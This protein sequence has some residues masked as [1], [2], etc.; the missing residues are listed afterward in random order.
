VNTPS[1]I[2]IPRP[3]FFYRIAL[4]LGVCVSWPIGNISAAENPRPNVIVIMSD[5]QGSID[6]GCY[7]A[8][9]IQTPAIDALAAS[10]VRFTQFY[11][12]APVCSP[13]R[14]GLLTGRYPWLVGMPGNGPVPP[15]EKD[16][17]LATYTGT[18]LPINGFTLPGMFR[19][20]GY[21]TAHIGKWHLG[22]GVGHQPLQ[23]GFDYSFGFMGGCIDNY[24]HFNYWDHDNRHDLWEN[25]KRV[26]MSGQFFPDLMIQKAKGFLDSHRSQP[27]F[28]YFAINVPHYPYQGDP[29]WLDYYNKQGVPYPR[30]LYAAFVSS[31]DDRVAQLINYLDQT[32]LRSNTIV[33]YQADN[34]YSTEQ[35]AHGGGGSSGPYRGAKFSIFEGGTRLPA[36]ISWP[37]HFPAGQ[38]RGQMA[39]GCDWL[40]TLAEC[41]GISLPATNNLDGRSL[42]K[43]IQS[44]D[45]TSPHAV[46]CWR[47]GDQW[48]VRE[49]PWK[50]MRDPKTYSKSPEPALVDGHWFL[51]NIE[52]DP[53]EQ[54]NLAAENPEVVE[55]LKKAF[56]SAST[57]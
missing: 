23:Q 31:M 14:A 55:R 17:D 16:D 43:V 18:G 40:P 13:S 19:A 7:G 45:A 49:G 25:G 51:A 27:F 3:T 56:E 22:I 32:G 10:G 5:D 21:T 50:L 52:N 35:R 41:C 48:A 6:A 4:L 1:L 9:D 26:R 28:M 53:G 30:N 46:L 47:Y 44:A 12:A 11:S 33:I 57:R 20:A 36:I 8:K 42:V 29:K 39:H 37:G 34:G 38:V 2:S 15:S 24:S 54:T